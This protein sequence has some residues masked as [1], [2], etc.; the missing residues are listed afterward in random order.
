MFLNRFGAVKRCFSSSGTSTVTVEAYK[1]VTV[2][3]LNRPEKQNAFNTEMVK[4][5][6]SAL[7]AFDDD[8]D[9]RVALIHGV[10]GNFSA[11]Y[12]TEDVENELK[13]TENGLN[14]FKVGAFAI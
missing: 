14:G 4:G 8:P 1:A 5:L 2:I 10:G 6:S 3:G 11:G 12:D 9:S 13:N 7:K